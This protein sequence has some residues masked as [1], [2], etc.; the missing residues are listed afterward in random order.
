MNEENSPDSAFLAQT[1]LV[2]VKPS[3]KRAFA[4]EGLAQEDNFAFGLIHNKFY[5]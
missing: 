3:C 4:H 2:F 1:K 5:N